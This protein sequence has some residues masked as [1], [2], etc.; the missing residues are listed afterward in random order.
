MLMMIEITNLRIEYNP[1][2]NKQRNNSAKK[3]T[4]AMLRDLI[5]EASK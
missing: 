1:N 2:R 5:M 4:N 3:I